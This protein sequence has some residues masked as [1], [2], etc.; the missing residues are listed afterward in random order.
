MPRLYVACYD[1]GL[2]P[3]ILKYLFSNSKRMKQNESSTCRHH[4][5][6][7]WAVVGPQ[8]SLGSHGHTCTRGELNLLIATL[9]TGPVGIAD[10]A[11]DS[12]ATLLQRSIRPDGLILQPDKPATSIDATFIDSPAAR[13]LQGHIW[14]TYA[15]MTSGLGLK[16]RWYYVLSIDVKV[17]WHLRQTDLFPRLGT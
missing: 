16:L 2:V 11:G 4:V 9:S 1:L 6:T 8:I 10:K 5:G 13:Q 3:S 14:S 15:A 17:S 7:C 12:N